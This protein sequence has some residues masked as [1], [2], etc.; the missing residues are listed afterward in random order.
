MP[1]AADVLENLTTVANGALPVAALWHTIVFTSLIAVAMG[2]RPPRRITAAM[3]VGLAASVSVVSFVFGNPF[4]GVS[5][6][7]LAGLS[8]R[9][10]G[11]FERERVR[12]AASWTPIPG[13]V[14]VGYGL[15]YP[16]FLENVPWVLYLLAAPLGLIPCPTLALMTGVTLIADRMFSA[17]WR[18]TLAAFGLF[19][20]LFG[21]IR[22]HVLLD[23]G[24][25]IGALALVLVVDTRTH[26]GVKHLWQ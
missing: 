25:L 24:L 17:S 7:L 15:V 11:H 2:W 19:Y 12:T 6:A 23:V 20:G 8:T 14:L 18:A 16:H 1:T 13:A 4:N 26:L 22:L 3:L 21:I 10:A 9:E 5:F